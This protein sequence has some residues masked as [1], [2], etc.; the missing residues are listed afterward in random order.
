VRTRNTGGIGWR[1][2]TRRGVTTTASFQGR[3]G[4]RA[5]IRERSARS[6]V[7]QPALRWFHVAFVRGQAGL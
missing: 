7:E 1:S 5:L 6:P 2:E 4:L 3:R